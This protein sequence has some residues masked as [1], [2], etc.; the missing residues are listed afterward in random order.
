MTSRE[1][2]FL[3]LALCALLIWGLLRGAL[4]LPSRPRRG[5]NAHVNIDGSVKREYRSAQA[6]ALAAAE[7]EHDF[8]HHMNPYKCAHGNHWHIGHA[9]R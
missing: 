9:K 3:V 7:Y 5:M 1:A 8:G 6:A 2:G 4:R